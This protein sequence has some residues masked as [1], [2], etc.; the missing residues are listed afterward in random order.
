M[1]Y[2]RMDWHYGADDFPKELDSRSGGTHIGM[3]LAWVIQN[4]LIGDFHIQESL[5][6]ISKV[7]ANEM[8]GTEFLIKECDE[9][10]WEEDLNEIGQEFTKYYYESNIYYGDYEAAIGGNFPTLYHIPETWANF[11]KVSSVVSKKYAKWL[12]TRNKKWWQI[13]K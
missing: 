4:D 3:Y 8:T 5:D 10:F 1:A 9:K 7:K 13:W 11:K 12:F 6:S 2:D